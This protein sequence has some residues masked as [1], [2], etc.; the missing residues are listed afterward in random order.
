MAEL[1]EIISRAR[2]MTAELLDMIILAIEV[3]QPKCLNVSLVEFRDGLQGARLG[4]TTCRGKWLFTETSQGWLLLNLG[5]VG[6][7]LMATRSNLPKKHRMVFDFS[8]ESCLMVN[9]WWFGYAHFVRPD[10]LARH[11]M[12]ARLGPNAVDMSPADLLKM[13]RWQKAG[14]KVL[15]LDQKNL[16]GF[17]N[18]YVHD[19][20]FRARLHSLR[21]LASLSDA[22]VE[23]LAHAVH[24]SLQSSID[25]G[26]DFY[27][28]GLHSEKGG[29][30]MRDILIGYKEG[31][32]CP[33]CGT[34]IE[35]IKTGST[36][37][38]ICPNCQ[39]I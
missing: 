18:T 14:V 38:F 21:S 25:K 26:G 39:P 6:E 15:L 36:S 2:G 5:M 33:V 22:D 4:Q 10:G 19:I 34:A 7:V 35:K 12:T 9:F 20:L 3:T 11:T 23:R 29:F 1:P 32:A 37:S 16:S 30:S 17:G 24:D 28:I 27:E 31:H 8:D 13:T